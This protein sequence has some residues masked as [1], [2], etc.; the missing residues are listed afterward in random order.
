MADEKISERVLGDRP[1][2]KIIQLVIAS[3]FV[4][5]IFRF[6]GIGPREFWSGLLNG[7]KN[8]VSE[9]GDSA[10]E[11]IITI[12]TYFTIGAAIVIPIWIIS[13]VLKGTPRNEPSRHRGPQD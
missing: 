3:I 6:L 7:I 5:A 1:A 9:I 11:I 8:L 13:R 12:L 4:G 10:L 2:R